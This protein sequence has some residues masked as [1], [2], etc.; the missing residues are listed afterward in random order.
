ML[1]NRRSQIPADYCHKEHSANNAQNCGLLDC[2][3]E[4]GTGS[5]VTGNVFKMSAARRSDRLIFFFSTTQQS[6]VGQGLLV[7]KASRSHSEKL[8]W[9]SDRPGA[10]DSTDNTGTHK[11]QTSI[12]SAGFEPTIP[13]SERLQ[14]H[15]RPLG[16]ALC[17]I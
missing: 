1:R 11:R 14:T 16:P 2:L 17:D 4:K 8:L 6:L 10:E 12:P 13:A 3:A 9:T 5:I 15:A 7:I